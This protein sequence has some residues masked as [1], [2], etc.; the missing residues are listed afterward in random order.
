MANV[1][2]LG[3]GNMGYAMAKRLIDAGHNVT[4]YNRTAP[5]A[6]QLTDAGAHQETSPA[7]AVADAE[8]IIS[9]VS[10][11]GASRAVWLGPE[12][13][14]E[15]NPNPRAVAIESSTLSLEWVLELNDAVTRAGYR[16]LDCPVTGGPDGAAAGT[17][18]LL[19]GG[20]QSTIEASADVTSAYSN[21]SI[22]FGP[23]GAG[24]SYKLMVNL[25][26]AVQ[27]AA[28][29]EGLA[30]A[31]KAELDLASVAEALTSG[32]VASP[33]VKYLTA[34]MVSGNH[35]DVYF[36]AGLR[37]KDAAYGVK[38]GEALGAELSVSK[39]ALEIYRKAID[40]GL[41]DKNSSIIFDLLKK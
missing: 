4:V 33:H 31:E 26:G 34:R 36:S 19:L 12:G 7:A 35:D 3:L 32:A 1:A 38:M 8:F 25:M 24:T 20:E 11:D 37:H 41:A 23:V 17:L 40:I 29:A 15:G 14:L 30:M 2:F 28:L 16:Y 18:M 21:R 6:Q 22:V 13:V 10:D 5:K 9:M 27:G 39:A